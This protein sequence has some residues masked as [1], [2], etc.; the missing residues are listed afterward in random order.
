MPDPDKITVAQAERLLADL[1]WRPDAHLLHRL[2]SDGRSSIRSLALRCQRAIGEYRAEKARLRRMHRY[3]RK[4]RSKG[5][6]LIGGIDE[7]GRGAL[8]GPV[9]AAVVVLQPDAFI[10]GLNDSKLLSPAKRREVFNLIGQRAL[11]IGVGWV[12]SNDVDLLNV[13]RATLLAMKRALL[14]AQVEPDYLLIDALKLS[15]VSIPQEP[16]IKGDRLS[17]SIAAASIVAKVI[18]DDMMVGYDDLYPGYGFSIN[19][20]YG[21]KA[22][23]ES[24]LMHGLCSIHRRSFTIKKFQV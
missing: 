17:A 10:E 3:E 18:R 20:G 15:D 4:A 13:Y 2:S 5:H 7:V 19:K 1:N 6:R 24:I 11:S 16:L 8:A 23:L 9:A 21:T 14:D 22:H 12:D